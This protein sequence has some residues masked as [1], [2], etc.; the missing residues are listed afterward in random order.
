MQDPYDNHLSEKSA[1]KIE[2]FTGEDLFKTNGN[3]KPIIEE[4]LY[5]MDVVMLLGSEKAGKSLLAIQMGMEIS[6]GGMLFDKYQC[7]QRKVIYLQTEGKKD[8]TVDRMLNMNQVIELDNNNFVRLYKK[9][10]PLNL[11]E[12]F[13]ALNKLLEDLNAYDSV[14][15]LDCLYMAMVGDLNDNEDVRDFLSALCRLLEKYRMTCIFVH[16]SKRDEYFQG[17]KIHKGDKSSYG[18]VF[19]RANID[20]ILFLD[21]DGKTKLRKLSCDT[22][23]G[24]K[25]AEYEQLMLVEPSP[26]HFKILGDRIRHAKEESILFHLN[27][28]PMTKDQLI[29]NTKIP[30]RTIDGYIKNLS[31]E[32][33]VEVVDEI[34]QDK[35]SPLKIYGLVQNVKTGCT[36]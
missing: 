1:I 31:S 11:P 28:K 35:G 15:I 12:Y 13:D 36:P 22:Q 24:G 25:V 26:L 34:K 3:T 8:E 10:C 6:K 33:L 2:S 19:L 18:S 29:D 16:H 30:K 20:H 32:N 27:K 17:E 21:M 9:F 5:E 23:R 7:Y 14:F 4:Y